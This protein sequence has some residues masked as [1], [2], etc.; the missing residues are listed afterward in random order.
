M[1]AARPEPLGFLPLHPLEFRILMILLK[2]PAHG[3]AVVQAI[4]ARETDLPAIY[5]GNLY[6]RIR[7]LR[8]KGLIEDARA[9]GSPE[10]D[11]RRRYFQ[12]TGL[13]REVASAEA[14]RL[15]NLVGEARR[16]GLLS[17]A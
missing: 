17:E 8:A 15:R 11:P 1:P 4:E 10:D 12:I 14:E 2:Q 7:D 6:R 3:Y 16:M 13:G 9:A 5:P